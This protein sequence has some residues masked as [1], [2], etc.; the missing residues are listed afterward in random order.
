MN[1]KLDG[2]EREPGK[3]VKETREGIRVTCEGFEL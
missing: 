3:K 2:R 1:L